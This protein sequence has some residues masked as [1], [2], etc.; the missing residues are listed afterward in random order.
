[1]YLGTLIAELES[2]LE[3]VKEDMEEYMHIPAVSDF[4]CR[5]EADLAAFKRLVRNYRFAEEDDVDYVVSKLKDKPINS[6]YLGICDR[7][8][9]YFEDLTCEA[10]MQIAFYE[11]S[12]TN[13]K[14]IHFDDDYAIPD[15][16]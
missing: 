9:G 15:E 4:I 6:K 13:E 8:A 1:M 11:M 12:K 16:L 2:A 10:K 3:K 14:D 5:K 7:K